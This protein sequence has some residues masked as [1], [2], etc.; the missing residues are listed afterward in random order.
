LAIDSW[1]ASVDDSIYSSD[2]DK[3]DGSHDYD[4]GNDSDVEGNTNNTAK[5]QE[6]IGDVEH[7][8]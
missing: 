3:S 1:Y 5:L 7:N 6:I 4:D 2:N 8:K